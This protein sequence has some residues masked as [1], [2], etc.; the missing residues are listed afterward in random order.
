MSGAAAFLERWDAAMA[1]RDVAPLAELIT[2]DC[3]IHSPAAWEPKRSRAFILDVLE[4]MLTVVDG[5]RRRGAWIVD[6]DRGI[7][8]EFEGAV[9]GRS[10]VGVQRMELDASGRMTRIEA[11]VRPF[12]G[13][14][15]LAAAMGERAALREAGSSEKA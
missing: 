5:Y 8:A 6:E 12:A 3:A 15:A 4:D 10:L 1:A 13:L 14:Q 7:I 2:E 11:W 9:G